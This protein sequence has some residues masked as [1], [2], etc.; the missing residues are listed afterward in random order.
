MRSCAWSPDGRLLAVA[1]YDNRVRIFCS[2]FWTLV[3]DIDHV[4]ALHEADPVTSRFVS[5]TV[6]MC[7]VY[8][9]GFVTS[10]AVVYNESSVE[11][12]EGDLE[13]RLALEMAG[14]GAGVFL[15][16]TR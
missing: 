8:I 12:E 7:T 4:G 14:G 5:F 9:T 15:S 2:Q 10:R 1:S 13:T 6:Y 11:T 3:H 16:Q